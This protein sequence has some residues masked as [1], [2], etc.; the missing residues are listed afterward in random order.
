MSQRLSF[1]IHIPYCAKRCGYCDFNT[2]TPSELKSGDLDSLSSSYIDSAIKEIEMAAQVVG[3]ATIPTIFFGGGTP[4]LLPAAQLA[5]VIEAIRGSFTLD[6]DIEITL[7]A[8]PDS[9]TQEFL[10]EIKSAGATRISMGMQSA[11]G[12][13]LKVLDRTHN[14][15]SVGRAVSM[16]RAA[17]FKHVSVDLIYGSPGETIDD[18]R[19]SLEYALALD[20]DHISAYALIVEKGTKLAAQINRGELTMPPDDQSADKYLLADQ[21]F[22]AAGFNWYELS[23]WSKPGGQCRHNIAYWDGSFWWGVGAG[24]HSY[25]NGKRW[26]NVKHPSSYQEKILQGQSPELSHEILTP[27]NLSDEFIMLQIRRREGILHNHLSSVQIAKAEEFLSSGFLDSASWQ[28]MRLV[29]SR[30]GRLIA[31][32][33]VREL[34]L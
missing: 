28:D 9:L 27:E 8:N 11:V 32:K 17:G 15:E 10:D 23:N 33:I 21:L 31:D 29:L 18:W 34:V 25:L 26:W 2:Y 12:S 6:K 20:I 1:Y 22:E 19:R 14:P 4:S 16:V 3:S 7:E 5:R 24:A 30:D 13:V